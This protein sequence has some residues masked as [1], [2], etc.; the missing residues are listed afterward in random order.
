MQVRQRGLHASAVEDPLELS[1]AHRG[2]RVASVG[3]GL[4]GGLKHRARRL[5]HRPVCEIACVLLQPRGAFLVAQQ[6]PPLAPRHDELAAAH[7]LLKTQ[8]RAV[9]EPHLQLSLAPHLVEQLDLQQRAHGTALLAIGVAAADDQGLALHAAEPTCT[10]RPRA[11]A[12]AV[13]GCSA[14][15]RGP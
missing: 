6:R 1:L 14:P 15:R 8:V 3:A 11:D 4:A 10:G 2:R 9:L 7:V 12:R 13:A 5:H